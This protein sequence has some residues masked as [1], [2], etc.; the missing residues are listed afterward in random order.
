[1]AD[2]LGQ[3][4]IDR[5]R[6]SPDGVALRVRQGDAYVDITWREL[7]PRIERVAAGLL[8]I[9]PKG[10]LPYGAAITIIG[11]TNV[12]WIV[13]DFAAQTLGFRTVPIY[14]SLLPENVGYCHA[15]L[16]AV[17]AICQN[18]EQLAKVRE[19]RGGFTFF[20]KKYDASAIKLERIV[21]M[22]PAGLLPGEDWESLAALEQRGADRMAEDALG[23]EIA[24]RRARP[25]RTDVATYTYTSGTTGPEK[26]VI[27]THDNM[28]SMLESTASTGLF[29][30]RVQFGGLFLFL[31]LAHSFGRLIELAGPFFGA[32][33]VLS[34]IPTLAEDLKLSLPG[35]FPSAPRVYEKM[36]AKIEGAV[37]GAPP[38]R[39]RLFHWAMA[40]GRA[41]VPYRTTGL[42]LPFGLRL[43]YRIADRLVLSKL[44][45]RLGFD[46]AEILL[47]GSAPLSSD[48]HEF[49]LAMGV[50]LLE[51]YGL[52]ETCPGL[53]ANLPGKIR[54]GTVGMAFDG[55]QIRIAEDGEILAKG[56]NITQGYHNRPDA[57]SAAFDADGWFHTGDLGSMDDDGFVKITGRKKELMKTS[58]GKYI[59]PTKLEGKL[60]S[61]PYVQEA[62]VFADRRNYVVALFA[63]DPEGLQTW[64]GQQGV[65]SDPRS[66][67]VVRALQTHVDEVNKS[68][69]SFETVKYFRVLPEPM[70]VDNGLLTAS[71]KVKRSVVEE[72]FGS[73]IDDMYKGSAASA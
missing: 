19:I 33:I 48:V 11:E 62:V 31:P 14:A 25:A 44:R 36:K 20:D 69:A 28:L 3:M 35:F 29:T 56:A 34:T 53:T 46:R 26:A 67:A 45:S 43:R 61:P 60:K 57:T 32:A 17:V 64:A 37:A 73:L 5:A 9:L 1:M 8:T 59:A 55:V 58:G 30:D 50:T 54:M 6:S 68:L 27:Q 10:L 22:E 4:V 21:V 71:L 72:R 39:Q 52:T 65:A 41:T 2:T 42:A 38:M 18:A 49:F 47:S 40:V 12:D 13:C 51:A 16:E 7:M 15:D 23:K 24:S 63:L 70:S 66:D